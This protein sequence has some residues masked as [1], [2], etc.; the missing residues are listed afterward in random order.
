MQHRLLFGFQANAKVQETIILDC[1]NVVKL[2]FCHFDLFIFSII[3]QNHNTNNYQKV[4]FVIG[5]LLY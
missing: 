3:Y 5:S 2:F 4:K 1:K